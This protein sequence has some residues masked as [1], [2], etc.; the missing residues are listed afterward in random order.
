MYKGGMWITTHNSL[1]FSLWIHTH[2]NNT[3]TIQLCQYFTRVKQYH[4][5]QSIL[6]MS[7]I[8]T[9]NKTTPHSISYVNIIRGY[10]N[11]I[12]QY[13]Y[14]IMSNG[15]K[16][17]LKGGIYIWGEESRVVTHLFIVCIF[18]HRPIFLSSVF[19]CL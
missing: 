15:I 19:F 6:S 7:H 13:I 1:Y 11:H 17:L 5:N 10:N 14:L 18:F 9:T 12:F 8:I 4:N 2:N 16:R 3:T